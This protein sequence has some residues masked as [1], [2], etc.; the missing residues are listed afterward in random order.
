MT[1]FGRD[2]SGTMK[3]THFK[4]QPDKSTANT[5]PTMCYSS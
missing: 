3:S 1:S 2:V 5:N 4:N